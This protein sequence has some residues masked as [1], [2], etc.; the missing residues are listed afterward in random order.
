MYRYFYY[1]TFIFIVY[2]L[3]NKNEMLNKK[4]I[5]STFAEAVK[6]SVV[7]N[8]SESTECS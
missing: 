3:E 2:I 7:V 6:A 5:Y 8:V 4:V 1:Y